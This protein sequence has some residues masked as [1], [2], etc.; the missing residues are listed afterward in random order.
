MSLIARGI[1]EPKAVELTAW[2]TDPRAAAKAFWVQYGFWPE[3]V[4]RDDGLELWTV[5]GG[6]EVCGEALLEDDDY[7]RQ[8][9]SVLLCRK[10]IDQSYEDE[11]D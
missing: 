6:C 9:E 7:E 11:E 3:E 4:Y 8:D 10:C 2:T 5:I 1:P